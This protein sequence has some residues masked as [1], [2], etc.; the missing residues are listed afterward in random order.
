MRNSVFSCLTAATRSSISLLIIAMS[1]PSFSAATKKQD[2]LLS[3]GYPFG[4]AF[5]LAFYHKTGPVSFT[6]KTAQAHAAATPTSKVQLG[7]KLGRLDLKE[8]ITEA[9]QYK[10]TGDYVLPEHKD[11]TLTGELTCGAAGP[12]FSLSAQQVMQQMRYKVTVAD[13]L[14]T[15]LSVVAGKPEQGVGFNV[16]VNK[17]LQLK[18]YDAVAFMRFGQVDLAL[19]HVSKAS[20]AMQLGDLTFSMHQQLKPKVMMAAKMTFSHENKDKPL[21]GQAGVRLELSAGRTFAVKAQCCGT[22]AISHRIKLS[23]AVTVLTA[24]QA[25]PRRPEDAQFGFKIKVNS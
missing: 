24:V 7:Y 2:D 21:C 11:V 19:K 5:A 15:T 23:E 20:D 12:H 18:T 14:L 10:L 9:S 13:S 6:A 3:K 16:A 17:L 22:L 8:T 4:N 25:H 1:L